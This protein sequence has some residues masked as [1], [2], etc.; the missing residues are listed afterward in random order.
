V[1]TFAGVAELAPVASAALGE[2]LVGVERLPGGSKKGVYR[3]VLAGGRTA[4]AYVWSPAENYWP[5][6]LDD[7]VFA[8]AS[9]LDLL[10][11]AEQ[12]LS[13]A[14]V[15][16][17]R[18]L[19]ADP[20]G[21]VYPA[22]VAVVEDIRGGSLEDLLA[23][24]AA[25][26]QLAELREMLAAMASVAD[27]RLGR[28]AHPDTTGRTAPQIVQDRALRHLDEA[29]AQVPALAA[30]R[31]A[32]ADLLGGDDPAP[33]ATYGLVHGEL[34]PDHVLLDDAGR[35]VLADIEGLTTFDVEWE[36]AFLA[37]RFGSHYDALRLP[38]LDPLRLRSYRL[39]HHLSLVAGPL[40]LVG[41]DHPEREL[42][43]EIAEFHAGRA[44]AYV[45]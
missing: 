4:V 30:A 35:P 41:G 29:A 23:R 36:H 20:S 7:D 31:D 9:G 45:S 16:T 19:W 18:V 28:P 14:G 6:D 17:P 44:L 3:L 37:L 33:R 39:A 5:A 2:R 15:R 13:A 43:A 34:G 27:P 42:M 25:D 10:L 12:R 8:D 38:G 26:D 1:R 11:A 24:G 32:L 21:A 40:R 22:D